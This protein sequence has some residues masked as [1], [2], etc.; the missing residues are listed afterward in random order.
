MTLT[1]EGEDL[2]FTCP[3]CHKSA[4]ARIYGPCPECVVSLQ[5]SMGGAGR[6][7]DVTDYEPK[8]NVVPN[9]VASKE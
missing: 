4:T 8:M 3:R 2:E 9:Q 5:A 1:P 6:D 7:I